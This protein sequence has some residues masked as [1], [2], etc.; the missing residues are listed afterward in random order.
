MPFPNPLATVYVVYGSDENDPFV[1]VMH[2][3]QQGVFT[4]DQA[5]ADALA[6]H[7]DANVGAELRLCIAADC[8]YIKTVVNINNAGVVFTAENA[9]TAGVGAVA[10]QSL[11][12]YAA[13][14]IRK[15]TAVGGKRGR[16]RWF[17]GC[18]PEA[19]QDTGY[20]TV[21]ARTAFQ[22]LGTVLITD[23]V[24]GANTWLD[25]HMSRADNT[26][27]QIDSVNAQRQLGTQRGRMKRSI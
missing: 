27:V 18:V 4:A 15:R 9:T 16:G 17:I 22:N 2:M 3:F 26:V 12:D 10:G 8:Q 5:E 11:P 24:I 25:G 23:A 14:V 20:L 13:V 1:I 19:S 21:G 7:I 6:S